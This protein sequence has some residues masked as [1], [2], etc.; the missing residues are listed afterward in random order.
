[1]IISILLTT[2]YYRVYYRSCTV[3]WLDRHLLPV[4]PSPIGPVDLHSAA[5][6]LPPQRSPPYSVLACQIQ[7]QAANAQLAVQCY[8]LYHMPVACELNP[9][10]TL[11]AYV[12][13]CLLDENIGQEQHKNVHRTSSCSMGVDVHN[14]EQGQSASRGSDPIIRPSPLHLALS[15]LS[16]LASHADIDHAESHHLTGHMTAAP[17]WVKIL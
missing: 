16:P 12:C 17:Q 10:L 1:M 3:R 4:D 14:P 2:E 9:V 5:R 13:V 15:A 8:V 7:V 6:Q 11:H